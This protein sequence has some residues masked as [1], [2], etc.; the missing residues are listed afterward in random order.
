MILGITYIACVAGDTRQTLSV[1]MEMGLVRKYDT[2]SQQH[3]IYLLVQPHT[4]EH[5]EMLLVKDGLPLAQEVIPF[6]EEPIINAAAK[7]VSDADIARLL[8][9]SQVMRPL[10]NQVAARLQ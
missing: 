2:L 1:P 3:E 10:D 9:L 5:V 7:L 4:M 6:E 8:K